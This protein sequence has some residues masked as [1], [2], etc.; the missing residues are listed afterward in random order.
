VFVFGL[1]RSAQFMSSNTLSY[2]D[3]PDRQLSRAT[4]LGG[5]LQ[6]LSVSLGV[7]VSAV[8]LAL[9]SAHSETLTPARFHDVFLLS[10]VIPLLSIPG[11]LTLG[12]DDGAR[13]ISRK[14]A[15]A[16]TEE[17]DSDAAA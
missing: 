17:Q 3:T 15:F 13:A 4:S 10:A 14:K 8:L 2:A 5:V 9:V 6:Q 1:T 12:R 16:E 11:F 7:S